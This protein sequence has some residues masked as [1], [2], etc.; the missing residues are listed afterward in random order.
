M[1]TPM[2]ANGLSVAVVVFLLIIPTQ[3]YAQLTPVTVFEFSTAN[4]PH[5]WKNVTFAVDAFP[6]GEKYEWV[7]F[8][9]SE[10]TTYAN[11]PDGVGDAWDDPYL[12]AY[13]PEPRSDGW[14]WGFTP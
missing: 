3:V 4:L 5:N 2:T 10:E 9:N 11:L 8:N 14:S 12:Q 7:K 13:D 1:K 6:I